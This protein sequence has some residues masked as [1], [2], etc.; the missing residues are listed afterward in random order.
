MSTWL[1]CTKLSYIILKPRVQFQS[2]PCVIYGA[3]S[4]V[5]AC[6]FSKYFGVS[7][8]SYHSKT[9]PVCHLS[10]NR[11]LRGCSTKELS[12]TPLS[13]CS[14]NQQNLTSSRDYLG[15]YVQAEFLTNIP[16]NVVWCKYDWWRNY[17]RILNTL[18]ASYPGE[19]RHMVYI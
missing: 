17:C 6:F 15:H 5:E 2:S 14:R 13:T 10:S 19:S 12:L 9:P 1:R 7:P 18:T 8:A 4:G 3:R 16:F 11:P